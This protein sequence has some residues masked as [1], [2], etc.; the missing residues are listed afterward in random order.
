MEKELT[1]KHGNRIACVDCP[2][3]KKYVHRT[4][5]TSNDLSYWAPIY[6]KKFKIKFTPGQLG[7]K[8]QAKD[9]EKAMREDYLSKHQFDK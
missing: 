7:Q 9:P 3:C 8:C 4:F 5:Y 2:Y 6:C 1:S